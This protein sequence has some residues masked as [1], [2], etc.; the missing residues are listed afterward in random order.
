MSGRAVRI[1]NVVLGAWLFVSAFLWTHTPA[2]RVSCWSVGLGVIALAVIA[3]TVEG[4]R[5]VNAAL[6]V[7][8]FA[9]AFALPH[10]HLATRWN[11]G[12]V[13]LLVFLLALV[14]SGAE[15]EPLAGPD[16]HAHA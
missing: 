12:V 8:L 5:W 11:E 14:P 16:G 7:W 9:S 13:A 15:P 6:A 4:A 3:T 2:D 10:L 1:L